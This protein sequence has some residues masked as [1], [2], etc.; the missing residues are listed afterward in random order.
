[1]L[2]R[3]WR[4]YWAGAWLAVL[5]LMLVP[6]G[7]LAPSGLAR[8]D[9]LPGDVAVLAWLGL[10]AVAGVLAVAGIAVWAYRFHTEPR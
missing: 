10:W 8:L 7:Y 9:V 2:G 1:M 5:G 3:L 4:N 6:F